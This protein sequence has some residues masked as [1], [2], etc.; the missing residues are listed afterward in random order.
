[1]ATGDF[2]TCFKPDPTDVWDLKEVFKGKDIKDHAV[3]WNLL[4]KEGMTNWDRG[5]PS[6]ALYEA[7]LGY[8]ELFSGRHPDLTQLKDFVGHG[9]GHEACS[10]PHAGARKR[11]EVP[12][13]KTLKGI[14][15][16]SRSKK[17]SALVPACG[18][19][20]DAALLAYVFGYDVYALDVSIEALSSAKDYLLAL[21]GGFR[22]T[23]NGP[24]DFPFWVENR[25]A[26]P[27]NV[28][29]FW[30]DFFDDCWL[31]AHEEMKGMKFD[32]IFDYTVSLLGEGGGG[33]RRRR[34]TLST[35][36]IGGRPANVPQVLLRHTT[37]RTSEVGGQNAATPRPP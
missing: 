17:L 35:H 28:K 12:K 5:G 8:P 23:S 20:Y 26:A 14:S 36:A 25:I 4:W 9:F 10:Q 6:M 7:I 27:G 1:M 33:R 19:G 31:E 29:L 16:D 30:A 21:E 13:S 2:G 15:D 18:S 34:R 24:P 3:L 11:K 22:G 37:H 32:L